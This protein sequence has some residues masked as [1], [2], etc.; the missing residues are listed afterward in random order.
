MDAAI[1]WLVSWLTLIVGVSWLV[2]WLVWI[3]GVCLP[4]GTELLAQAVDSSLLGCDHL[5]EHRPIRRPAALVTLQGRPAQRL[6]Q[7]VHGARLFL[8]R[9]FKPLFQPRELPV[10]EALFID[11]RAHLLAVHLVACTQVLQRLPMRVEL[12]CPNY[13]RR[14]Q[15][16]HRRSLDQ[17]ALRHAEQ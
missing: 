5:L 13:R 17:R 7:G 10:Q 2:S 15:G 11:Q 16:A 9:L 3:V 12:V 1:P 14:R 4:G 6:S 8:R